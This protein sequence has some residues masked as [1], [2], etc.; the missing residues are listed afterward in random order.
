MFLYF[1]AF[2]GKKICTLLTPPLSPLS[3]LLLLLLFIAAHDAHSLSISWKQLK[4]NK[5]PEKRKK[6]ESEPPTFSPFLSPL[7]R[8]K[9]PA[10]L[11]KTKKKRPQIPSLTIKLTQ[12]HSIVHSSSPPSPPSRPRR[13][14][15]RAPESPSPPR[16]RSGRSSRPTRRSRG[17]TSRPWSGR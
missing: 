5:R 1:F 9:K 11:F 17:R 7:A 14:P 2:F 12:A 3:L 16:R 4:E 8:A 10:S 13:W 15:P 6:K